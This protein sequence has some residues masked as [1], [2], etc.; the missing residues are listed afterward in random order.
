M[1]GRQSRSGDDENDR[2]G[3]VGRK[4]VFCPRLQSFDVEELIETCEHCN[5]FF[6]HCCSC[7]MENRRR[8]TTKVC[9]HFR[10]IFTDGACRQ[11]GKSNAWAGTGAAFGTDQENQFSRP[12]DSLMDAGKRTSQRAELLAALHGIHFIHEH[13]GPDE[14]VETGSKSGKKYT[15][16]LPANERKSFIIATDSEYVVKGITEWLPEWEVSRCHSPDLCASRPFGKYHHADPRRVGQ[17]L[18]Q[19]TWSDTC[20][21]GPISRT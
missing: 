12:I 5:E 3:I 10:L 21:S 4:M 16:P 2:E 18:S 7:W 9:H 20:K 8:T 1:S 11:N 13:R 6:L 14:D 15:K 19:C 17:R